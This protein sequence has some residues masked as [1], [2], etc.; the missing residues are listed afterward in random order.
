SSPSTDPG[1]TSPAISAVMVPGPHPTSRTS[2][3]ATSGARGRRRSSP[4]SATGAS[5]G[6][7]RRARGCT[8]PRARGPSRAPQPGGHLGTEG[9]GVVAG[10]G[11]AGRRGVDVGGEHAGE[12]DPAVVDGGVGAGRQVAVA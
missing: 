4:P 2:V 9:R 3:P 5:A 11:V 8:R 6:R 7:R 1:A 12:G 10:G